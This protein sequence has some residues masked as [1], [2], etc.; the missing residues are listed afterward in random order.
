[1]G[2]DEA[3][4]WHVASVE[5]GALADSAAEDA[6]D[7]WVDDDERWWD[8]A[9]DG[10]GA[11]DGGNAGGGGDAGGGGSGG[12]GQVRRVVFGGGSP[13]L[14]VLV[15]I[16]AAVLGV[17]AG[18]AFI[19]RP[20]G[21]TAGS[22]GAGASPSAGTGPGQNSGGS[23]G[24]LPTLSP[25]PGNGNGGLQVQVTGTVTA[26]S[27]TS[28][29]VGGE[30]TAVTARFTGAT[31]FTGQVQHAA[32]IKDGDEVAAILTGTPGELTVQTIQDPASASLTGAA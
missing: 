7:P 19:N 9:A 27:S 28:I 22:P 16:V 6:V 8:V 21:A 29:T 30:G 5:D 11:A 25:L 1:M 18:L 20:S 14:T 24:G 4:E 26:V 10:E 15:A 12:A 3:E 17:I 32:D 31:K 13:R 23:S 2:P